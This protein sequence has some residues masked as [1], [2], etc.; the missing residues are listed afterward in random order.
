MVCSSNTLNKSLLPWQVHNEITQRQRL[1]GEKA[2][3]REGLSQAAEMMEERKKS[4][5]QRRVE[6]QPR[7]KKETVKLSFMTSQRRSYRSVYMVLF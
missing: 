2:E 5:N 7:V 1:C 6:E 4:V 3:E